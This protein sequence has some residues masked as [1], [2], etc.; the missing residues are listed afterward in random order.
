MKVVLFESMKVQER[1]HARGGKF[2]FYRPLEGVPGSLGNFSATISVLDREF[3]SPRHRHNFEQVRFQ[4]ADGT[5]YDS[6]G[7]MDAGTVG[8][9]PEGTRYGPQTNTG[10]NSTALN[11]QFGGPSHS[12]YLSDAQFQKGLAE[13]KAHGEFKDG[14]YTRTS[15]DGKKVNTDGYQAVW[16]HINGR[17][18]EYPKQ[19]YNRCTIMDP[20]AFEWVENGGGTASKLLGVFS[21]LNTKI[22]FHR[23]DQ[24]ARLAL[25]ANSVYFVWIGSGDADR[26]PWRKWTSIQVFDGERGEM[27]AAERS[28]VLQVRLPFAQHGSLAQREAA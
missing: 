1:A 21:E 22:A 13:L 6:D 8:Y 15:P 26:Q 16:E 10:D 9:F 17:K 24:G 18:L 27:R 23:I 3:V 12:G 4:L 5:D 11:L 28:E 7:L 2:L 25:E 20:A 19:R 14:Y